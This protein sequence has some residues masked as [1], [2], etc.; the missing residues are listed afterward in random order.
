MALVGYAIH[1]I[2]RYKRQD[3][4]MFSPVNLPYWGLIGIG[5]FSAIYHAT[6]KYHTQMGEW[7]WPQAVRR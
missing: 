3:V 6:L 5:V 2:R 4:G 1:G 7:L